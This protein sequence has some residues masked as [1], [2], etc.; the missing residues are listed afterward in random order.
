MNSTRANTTLL[1]AAP[2]QH[3]QAQKGNAVVEFAFI[4][5]LFLSLILGMITFSIALY[6]KTVL[7][8]AAREGARAGAISASAST[9]VSDAITAAG[10]ACQH[11]LI[12]F[13]GS[14]SPDFSHTKISTSGSDIIVT[15]SYR[16]IG[17]YLWSSGFDITAETTMR[18]E[19][20]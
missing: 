19:N 10:L 20:P 14:A 4:L 7:T 18:L 11:N 2:K 1:K 16:Y 9:S 8:M 15:G 17:L 3:A 6:D 13:G 5:P 12:S